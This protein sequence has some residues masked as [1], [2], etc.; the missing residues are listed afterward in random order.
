[1]TNVAKKEGYTLEQ[2]GAELIALLADGAFRDAQGILQK[3]ISFAKGKSVSLSDIEEVTGA[4]NSNLVDNFL[5][6]LAEN[7]IERGY[8]AIGDASSQN[9][10]MQVYL[11]MI[12]V[13]LRYALMLRYAPAYKKY[14]EQIISGEDLKYIEELI[15]DKPQNISSNTLSI[16]LEAYQSM[17]HSVISELPLELALVKILHVEK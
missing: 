8:K 13:K 9:I 11:K 14:I 6:A 4:P 3:V 2:G 5:N 12:L 16:L 15:K 1:M 7:D 17:R 10:D